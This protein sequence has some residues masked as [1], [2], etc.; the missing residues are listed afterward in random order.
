MARTRFVFFTSVLRLLKHF[1]VDVRLTSFIL[2]LGTV[3]AVHISNIIGL[4]ALAHSPVVNPIVQ[5]PSN[6]SQLL[7]SGRK[8]YEA[9]LFSQSVTVWQQAL[10]VFKSQ[11]N[12]LEQ[13]VVLLD[14][15]L[16]YRSLDN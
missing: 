3:L 14:L 12:I 2:F 6:P 11:Q 9:G 15:S 5:G 1:Q 13:A 10:E 16:A 7:Q 4:P 8:L